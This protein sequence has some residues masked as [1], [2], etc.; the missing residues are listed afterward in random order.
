VLFC[1]REPFFS[2]KGDI[3]LSA[4]LLFVIGMLCSMLFSAIMQSI[5]I[6]FIGIVITLFICA[7]ALLYGA[8][9][10]N[11]GD[12]SAISNLSQFS[13]TIPE[14][15]LA[16]TKTGGVNIKKRAVSGRLYQVRRTGGRICYYDENLIDVTELVLASLIDF[17]YILY[18]EDD[19]RRAGLLA[20]DDLYIPSG[21]CDD[22]NGSS[23]SGISGHSNSLSDDS[24]S[25]NSYDSSD[26]GG[27]DSGSSYDSGGSS[28]DSGGSS[29][30]SGGS[31]SGCDSD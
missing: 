19:L 26:N 10:H 14:R 3:M 15:K 27:S 16:E 30:D 24:I 20:P 25:H 8:P 6:L 12:H 1:G 9:I 5:S 29:Y 23:N 11:F 7:I 18:K 21:G 2:H 13:T 4:L 31:D 22:L 28:Y 17:T